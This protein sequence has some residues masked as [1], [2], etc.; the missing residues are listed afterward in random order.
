MGL[1]RMA[2]APASASS[3]SRLGASTP[4][5]PMTGAAGR[6]APGSSSRAVDLL[7]AAQRYSEPEQRTIEDVCVKLVAGPKQ[8]TALAEILN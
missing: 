6:L 5:S 4:T 3:F 8:A 2:V 1:R 7:H